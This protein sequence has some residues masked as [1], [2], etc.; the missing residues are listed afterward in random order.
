MGWKKY[1]EIRKKKKII[2]KKII[3]NE[4][5]IKK[6][7]KKKKKKMDIGGLVLFLKKNKLKIKQK[8]FINVHY[9]YGIEAFVVDCV[10]KPHLSLTTISRCI[11]YKLNH[12]SNDQV[13]RDE[14]QLHSKNVWNK[15]LFIIKAGEAIYVPLSVE[16]QY[17]ITNRH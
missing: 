13:Q 11:T 6:M 1:K 5:K 7:Y 17:I 15:I 3:I 9:I 2:I 8:A 10:L 16:D 14:F 12:A 4:K